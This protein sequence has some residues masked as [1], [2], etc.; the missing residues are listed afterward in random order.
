MH[1]SHLIA[2]AMVVA[3]TS[4]TSNSTI[5]GDLNGW[6]PC[7]DSDEGSSSQDAE[8]AVYNA[9][10]CYPSICEA[11]KSANPKVDIFFKRIPATTGDPEMAPNVWLLQ[12][13]P[14]DSSSGLEAN[15]IT[16]HSQLEGAVNV[17]TMDHRGTG[18][19]T[20]LDCVAAQATT[21]GS[22]W[23]SELDPSE[24]PA[25]AQDL[26]NKYGDLASFSVTTAATDLATF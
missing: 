18:R 24:V 4:A 21:T 11:P 8:C 22:P 14:G 9:P 10:L 23:G 19:S 15:M 20:R 3:H 13:G 26:H 7:A 5:K 17:Y 2:V 1:L 16:L 6:Y 25:C 12:G